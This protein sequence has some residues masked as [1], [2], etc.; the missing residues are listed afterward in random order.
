MRA[1]AARHPQRVFELFY[2]QLVADPE[3]R[4]RA[5]FAF[6]GEPWEPAVLAFHEKPHDRWAGHQDIKAVAS[7][8]F[9]PNVGGW[10]GDPP[11][12]VKAML[13]QAGEQLRELGYDDAGA[14]P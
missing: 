9:E 2:E 7:R 8:G 3:A 11:E 5:L 14:R 4:A 12:R 13:E 10:R 6:L 1:F